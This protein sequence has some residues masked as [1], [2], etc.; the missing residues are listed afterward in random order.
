M[1][2]EKGECS[3][4]SSCRTV[5]SNKPFLMLCSHQILVVEEAEERG[6]EQA[7]GGPPC[8]EGQ[9]PSKKQGG[10]NSPQSPESDR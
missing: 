5:Q 2:A 9:E 1:V 8:E 4:A 7:G 6:G 3:R 10:E